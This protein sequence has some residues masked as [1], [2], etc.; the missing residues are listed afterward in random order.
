MIKALVYFYLTCAVRENDKSFITN[1]IQNICDLLAKAP[2]VCEWIIE[3]F[4]LPIYIKEF[5]LECSKK[6]VRKYVITL[7][8]TAMNHNNNDEMN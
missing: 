5:Q 1:N 8:I 6:V 3:C 7:I 4:T 2:K